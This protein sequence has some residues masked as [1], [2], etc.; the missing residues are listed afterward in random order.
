MRT[1]DGIYRNLIYN[2]MSGGSGTTRHVPPYSVYVKPGGNLFK[3]IKTKGLKMG[4]ALSSNLIKD[5]KGDVKKTAI[6]LGKDVLFNQKKD[7]KKALLSTMKKNSKDILSKGAKTL[8]KT[9]KTGSGKKRKKK[10][11]GKQQKRKRSG[12]NRSSKLGI[13]SAS[14]QQKYK[15][16]TIF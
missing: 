5:L 8:M 2:V 16:R 9:L 14:S 12:G 4:K 13:K 7:L 6:E 10:A 1:S 11:G 15:T 3:K